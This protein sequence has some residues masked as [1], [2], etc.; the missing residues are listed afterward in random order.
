VF[1]LAFL[2][3]MC[4]SSCWRG[5]ERAHAGRGE[6]GTGDR[7]MKGG[8]ETEDGRRPTQKELHHFILLPTLLH[9]VRARASTSTSHT[10]PMDR[11]ST[12]TSAVDALASA[13][14]AGGQQGSRPALS[15]KLRATAVGVLCGRGGGE[16]GA[17]DGGRWRQVCVLREVAAME[18][19][20]GGR[21]AWAH[22]RPG[23][24][25]I[26]KRLSGGGD[27]KKRKRKKT[28]AGSSSLT[29]HAPLAS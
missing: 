9:C 4:C 1:V 15:T 27:E 23:R 19:A 7:E 25:P 22:A 24:D 29:P 2:L 11:T 13:A 5:G 3:W 20:P 12:I 18:G 8:G 6:R 10:S 26:L 21:A 14:A 17:A 16:A 28:P